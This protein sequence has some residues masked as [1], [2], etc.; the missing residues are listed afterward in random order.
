MA[1]SFRFTIAIRRALSLRLTLRAATSDRAEAARLEN[2][3]S[4]LR[5]L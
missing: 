3:L 1:L 4:G 5:Y 2:L